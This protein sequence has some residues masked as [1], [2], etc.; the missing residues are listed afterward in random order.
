LLLLRVSGWVLLASALWF[1]ARDGLAL[2]ET[3][4]FDPTPLGQVWADIDR[5][6]LLLLEPGIVRHVHPALWE[7]VAFPL[8]QAP[9]A[10]VFAFPGLV[11]AVA[12][13][14]R[15]PRRRRRPGWN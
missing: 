7:W 8:L 14:S 10:L 5:D 2:L 9:A 1:C 15:T 12:A 11:L 13:R 6:S 4:F 3:G